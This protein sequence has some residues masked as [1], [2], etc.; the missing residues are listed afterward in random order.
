MFICVCA[1]AKTD[2]ERKEA[3]KAP[4][5]MRLPPVDSQRPGTGELYQ[6]SEV[7]IFSQLQHTATP[8]TTLQHATTRQ[9]LVSTQRG[10]HSYDVE[11]FSNFNRHIQF[12]KH[13]NNFLSPKECTQD[14]SQNSEVCIQHIPNNSKD[15]LLQFFFL[16]QNED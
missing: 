2:V 15:G 5:G 13:M 3:K 10:V 14:V 6:N 7:R 8:C 4:N 1:D 16:G 9:R 11:F 12:D